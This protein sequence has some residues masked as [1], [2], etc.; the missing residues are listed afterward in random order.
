LVEYPELSDLELSAKEFESFGFY[1]GNHPSSKYQGPEYTKIIDVPNRLFSNIKMVVLVEKISRIK[2]K[3][4]DDMAFVS[5][6]D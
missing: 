3:K 2:T 1:V 5:V 6:S 4:G